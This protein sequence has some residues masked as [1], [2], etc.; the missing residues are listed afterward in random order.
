MPAHL[1]MKRAGE[2]LIC[3]LAAPVV[4]PLCALLCIAVR[5]D[6][7]GAALFVQ[8][9]VG[10]D[11]RNFR[12]LK[13]RTMLVQTGDVPSHHV[14]ANRITRV[15]RV[16]RKWKLDELPQLLNVFVGSMSLVGPRP[17]LPT[18]SEVILARQ[19][20]HLLRYRPGITGPAQLAGVDMSD[21]EGLAKIE[22]D[23][24][25]RATFWNEFMLVVRTV[26]GS[27]RGDAANRRARTD[28]C[29]PACDS[30]V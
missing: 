7:P 12:M 10:K 18:Q 4:L 28:E 30:D 11:G 19:R 8:A 24:Y 22:A 2:L 26:S 25:L 17:C 20:H 13:L 16:L 9:R 5:L 3:V 21:P 14:N 6:S 1:S 27:G 23:F 29:G 15:G